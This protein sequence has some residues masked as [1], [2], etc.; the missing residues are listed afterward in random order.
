M[1]Q[2]K[3]T[4]ALSLTIRKRIYTDTRRNPIDV[5]K[6]WFNKAPF[7]GWIILAVV[8]LAAAWGTYK[9]E[10]AHYQPQYLANRVQYD[11]VKRNSAIDQDWKNGVF[12]HFFQ[13]G[14]DP[15]IS[16]DYFYF[17]C[18]G[19]EIVSWSTNR[20]D[21][22]PAVIEHPEA[23][24]QG[25]VVNLLSRVFYIRADS[26]PYRVSGDTAYR[27]FTL[28]P[29]AADYKID[30]QYFRSCFFADKRIPAATVVTPEPVQGSIAVTNGSGKVFF[31]LSFDE[32]PA[33][34]YKVGPLV[35]VFS[36][37]G[38]V[39]I[40]LFIHYLCLEFG[41]R[42]GPFWGWVLL[43]VCC[44]LL[45]IV[46][47][48]APMPTGFANTQLF[49]PELLASGDTI[50]SFG[51][52]L[53]SV[54][55]D[56]W[57][58]LYLFQNV[59]IRKRPFFKHPLPDKLFRLLLCLLLISDLYNGQAVSMYQLIIDS[60]ISFE[61]SDFYNI[62]IYTFLGIATI[63]V[64]TVNVLAILAI[65][66][67]M[68]KTLSGNYWLRYILVVGLSLACIYGLGK[69]E[70]VF[71]LAVLFMALAG[72]L[73]IDALGLPFI[74][75]VKSELSNSP[76]NYIWFAI[77][78]SWVTLEIFYFN[79]SKEKEL[80]KIFASKQEQRDDALVNLAFEEAGSK[81]LQDTVIKTYWAQPS[82]VEQNRINKYIF[83]N[84]LAEQLR[85]FDIGIYYYD[86]DHKPLF[87]RDTMDAAL[88]R[89]AGEVSGHPFAAGLVNIERA[90]AKNKVYW[91]LCPVL[92]AGDTLGF[93]GLDFSR[94]RRPQKSY[95]PA[96]LQ[97]KSN[98]TD[99][100]YYDKYTYAIYRNNTLWMQNGTE[101]FPNRINPYTAESEFTFR[102]SLRSS[103][104]DF[105]PE[106]GEII[107]VV[108]KRNLFA[109][110]VAL[111]SYVLAVFIVIGGLI[112]LVWHLLYYLKHGRM[113]YGRFNLSIRSK[114]NLTILVT[115]FI[116][117][118]VV[119]AI[120]MGFL[121]NKYKQS[122]RNGLRSKLFYFAQNINHLAEDRAQNVS[123]A[124]F[125]SL[126][127]S[128]D[129]GY[130]LS[131][132]AEDQGSE[133]NLYDRNG[134]LIA[135]SQNE[136]LQK[137]ITSRLMCRSAF[138]ALRS[139]NETEVIKK[140]KIGVLDYESAY[141]PLTD[142]KDQVLAYVNLP[143]YEA[144]SELNQEISGILGSLINI[145]TLI[146]FISGITAILI[147]NS[148]IRS[149]HLLITQFR[150]IRLKHNKLIEWPYR[151]EIGLLVNEYN[152]MMQK[153]EEM[154]SK[155]ART[156]RESAW[157]EIARQVAHEIK[158]PL[159]PMKLNI[160]YLQ[161]AI[162]NGRT[163]IDVLAGRVSETLIEQIENL[164]VIASEFSNFARMPDA[165]P[166]PLP[167][168]EILASIVDLF[169]VEDHT[170]ILLEEG[171]RAL[172]V[173][174]D[175]SYFIRIFTN[176]IKNA[177]Q[178][179]P[180]EVAGEIR[181]R[182]S[183][184]D[185]GVEIA[186]QDNGTGIPEDMIEKLFV[187][188]FT[189]KSSGTGIGLPMTKNMVEHSGGRIR[190]ETEKNRGT[191]FLVWLPEPDRG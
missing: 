23:Y 118:V 110:S 181:I 12:E 156:E 87:N 40:L 70:Y 117:L 136:L 18:K 165:T 102:E 67:E 138:V 64:I 163:D 31:Y 145:Y 171:D 20:V 116:S 108:Y 109:D 90:I 133:V 61:V 13:N 22:S 164:N 48:Y 46:H 120:T 6:K 11:L 26:I 79:Y 148:I 126:A 30:N 51:D 24:Y 174:A 137:G 55:F 114:V 76:K 122:Q 94:S 154:A 128:Y 101:L 155:L 158:N 139:R 21:L 162:K 37:L 27:V 47:V 170:R 88:I 71:S 65:T 188:Y 153:V 44:M 39:C 166:E 33:L 152:V 179:I 16:G 74:R 1:E 95:V 42:K 151:D 4:G 84:Y 96:F 142:N 180:E 32:D 121:S 186:V 53:R 5:L 159:T 10:V 123:A 157:R 19:R 119:G 38:L 82:A 83:Y 45:S 172:T 147:S 150:L 144:S 140:E 41:R 99:Q 25:A 8:F 50:R 124:T 125:D 177:T 129:F 149:F 28:I 132:L 183:L 69:H 185:E 113:M 93:I 80:R 161:Q 77:L 68:L 92:D 131:M 187:P 135:T 35:W 43:L 72:L 173:Y 134:L 103:V 105:R 143:Y 60:K 59:P 9:L 98:P 49:S 15:V 54:V 7:P 100:I 14:L 58:L 86:N 75:R 57:L 104:L 52:L 56:C 107:R 111:F 36:L 63:S 3:I 85:K 89:V 29:I 81:L 169:Q 141:T 160:Q 112:L 176:I 34:S 190:F 189:T 91:G 168:Y 127:L 167:V 115:V 182:F 2:S 17:I 66:N 130:K 78:C 62:T 178:A 184:V 97:R 191:T 175:K 106:K 73:L 146:F